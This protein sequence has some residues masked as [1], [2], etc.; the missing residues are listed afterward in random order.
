LWDFSAIAA[1]PSG[2]EV[3]FFGLGVS[4]AGMNETEYAHVT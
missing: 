3:C 2:L 1:E 4:A